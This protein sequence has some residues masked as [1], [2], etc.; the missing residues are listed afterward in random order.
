MIFWLEALNSREPIVSSFGAPVT[1]KAPV[2]GLVW[3]T[4]SPAEVSASSPLSELGGDVLL[5]PEQLDRKL[6]AI[7][8]MEWFRANPRPQG[9]EWE[10]RENLLVGP[11][12]YAR[13]VFDL[14]GGIDFLLTQARRRDISGTTAMV[15]SA[16]AQDYACQLVGHQFAKPAMMREVLAEVELSDTP[17][18]PAADARIRQAILS[19]H[20]RVLGEVIDETDP[21]FQITYDLFVTLQREGSQQV[22]QAQDPTAAAALPQRCWGVEGWIDEQYFSALDHPDTSYTPDKQDPEYTHRAWQ[23]VLTYVLRSYSFLYQ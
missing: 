14:Y 11:G 22:A 2:L 23:G 13:D 9:I 8:G 7:F 12:R 6:R 1:S 15:Q 5:T 10:W 20:E 3:M 16:L 21:R 17:A 4:I 19:L 18:D